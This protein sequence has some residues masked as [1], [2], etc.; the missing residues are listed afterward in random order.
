MEKIV[1]AILSGDTVLLIDNID[2]C[3]IIGSGLAL[4]VNWR[5]GDRNGYQGPREGFTEVLKVNTT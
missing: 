5:T 2:R 4:K 3:L 1:N